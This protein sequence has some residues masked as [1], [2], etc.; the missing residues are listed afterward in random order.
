MMHNNVKR[1][2]L[3]WIMNSNLVPENPTYT[4]QMRNAIII[5]TLEILKKITELNS[6][7]SKLL[8]L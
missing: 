8:S 4:K 5:T 2:L 6:I 1:N 3:K 7:S